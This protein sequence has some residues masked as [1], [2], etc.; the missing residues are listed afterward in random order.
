MRKVNFNNNKKLDELESMS[1]K[2]MEDAGSKYHPFIQNE[3]LF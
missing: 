2:E 3:N 1:K